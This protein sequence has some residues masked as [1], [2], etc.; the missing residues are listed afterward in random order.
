MAGLCRNRTDQRRH[1]VSQ[2][3]L[4]T[5]ASTSYATS[6]ILRLSYYKDFKAWG[7]EKINLA[8][9]SHMERT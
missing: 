1:N 4:K 9:Y 6:P 8:E 7:Q 3:V 2:K 5:Q